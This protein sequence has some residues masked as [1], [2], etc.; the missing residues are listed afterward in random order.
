MESHRVWILC[1]SIIAL[2]NIDLDAKYFLVELEN[3]NRTIYN[4]I[5]SSGN[6][7]SLSN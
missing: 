3:D 6:G 2:G 1:L 5:D 7:K 4:T